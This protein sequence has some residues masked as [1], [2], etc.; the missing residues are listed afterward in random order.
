MASL[1]KNEEGS[2]MAGTKA[3]PK[4]ELETWTSWEAEY[5]PIPRLL[6]DGPGFDGILAR[7]TDKIYGDDPGPLRRWGEIGVI[8]RFRKSVIF[9]IADPMDAELGSRSPVQSVLHAAQRIEDFQKDVGLFV[10]R[11]GL[12]GDVYA[13]RVFTSMRQSEDEG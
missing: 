6:S 8:G 11:L 7:I 1:T 10:A 4:G 12:E 5:K 3:L 2:A 13:R 9:D